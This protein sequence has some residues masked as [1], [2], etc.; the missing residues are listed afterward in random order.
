[1]RDELVV[2]ELV[3]VVDWG[4]WVVGGGA[5]GLGVEGE[6][7]VWLGDGGGL[8]LLWLGGGGG[9]ETCCL[10]RGPIVVMP[11]RGVMRVQVLATSTIT[12]LSDESWRVVDLPTVEQ[13]LLAQ[14][15]LVIL[16]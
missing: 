12:R 6:H 3:L 1:M 16:N 8:M 5:G 10:V 14:D 4:L 2:M 15:Q 13:L 7:V 9:E 11:W